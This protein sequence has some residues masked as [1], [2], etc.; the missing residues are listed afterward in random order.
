MVDEQSADG[1]QG[2][3][4][5]SFASQS[6]S[7]V[8]S[9]GR[10]GGLNRGDPARSIMRRSLEHCPLENPVCFQHPFSGVSSGIQS[11]DRAIQSTQIGLVQAISWSTWTTRTQ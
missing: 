7:P 3:I 11:A 9:V 5:E 10:H 1:K 2:T 8:S 6:R 4:F